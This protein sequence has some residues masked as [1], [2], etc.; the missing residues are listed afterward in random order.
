MFRDIRD[1]SERVK[2][3]CDYASQITEVDVNIPTS[4]YFRSGKEILR[5][6]DVYQSEGSLE[7]AFILYSKFVM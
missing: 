3:I 5:M 4:R 6:A 1:P 2:K 7:K